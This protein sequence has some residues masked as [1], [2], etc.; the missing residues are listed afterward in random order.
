[1][2]KREGSNKQPDGAAATMRHMGLVSTLA[3]GI[4][5]GAWL[6][7]KWDMSAGHEMAWGTALG[8]MTG[9]AAALTSVFRSL[10]K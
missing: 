5:G 8:A 1:M 2:E 7:H 10:G 4:G 9:L 6:G 3:V